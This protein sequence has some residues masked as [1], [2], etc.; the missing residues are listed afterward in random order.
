MKISQETIN[1]L[2]NFST[3]NKNIAIYTGDDIIQ[4][5]SDSESEFA[6]ARIKDSFPVNITLNDLGEF[7]NITNLF[8][9]PEYIFTDTSVTIR[10]DGAKRGGVCLKFASPHHLTILEKG[11]KWNAPDENL[12]ID[13]SW[14]KLNQ[15]IKTASILGLPNIQINADSNGVT[16]KIYNK[17]YP[18]GS[19]EGNI[20]L[21]NEPYND[22]I[23]LCFDASK[24]KMI[25]NYN[26]QLFIYESGFIK[27]SSGN[28]DYNY[29][30]AAESD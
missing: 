10:E 3:I 1:V 9:D 22:R 30:M 11:K 26:Y 18:D 7:L 19:K 2:K 6:N 27:W 20:V 5:I 12:R 25:T 8:N 24:F 13:V 21:S 15:I 17:M 29:I 16:A 14:E 28:G 23:E 4:T